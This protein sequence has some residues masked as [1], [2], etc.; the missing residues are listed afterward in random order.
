M[1]ILTIDNKKNEKY[2]RTPV[3]PL[4]FTKE[5][6]EE[7]RRIIREMREAMREARGVGL[8][9]NQVGVSKRLF[10]AQVPDGEG[11]QKFY[12]IL[13]PEIIKFSDERVSA[14]EG[15]LSIPH[16]FGD[17]LRNRILTLMGLSPA[18]KK[19][20]IKAWG[21]LARVFQHELDHLDGKLFIDKA[22][23]VHTMTNDNDNNRI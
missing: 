11:R 7:L 12:A 1:K 5:K 9:A 23:N 13:N 10:I 14:T 17:V 4:D 6:P 16:W 15:C 20:K 3:P 22:V 19:L 2:L 21:L 18:G 8:S